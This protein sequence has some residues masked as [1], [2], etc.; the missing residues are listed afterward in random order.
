MH[1]GHLFFSSA[2][3]EIFNRLEKLEATAKSNVKYIKT[4]QRDKWSEINNRI[5]TELEK[6]AI[7]IE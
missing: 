5:R 4:E 7:S 6:L 1:R 2:M 3:G